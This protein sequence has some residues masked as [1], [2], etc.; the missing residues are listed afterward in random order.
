MSDLGNFAKK[1][2]SLEANMNRRNG[3]AKSLADDFADKLPPS[4]GG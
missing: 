2:R 4:I 3:I 1:L